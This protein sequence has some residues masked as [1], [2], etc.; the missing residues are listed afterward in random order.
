[1]S[2]FFLS[3]SLS[4]HSFLSPPPSIPFLLPTPTQ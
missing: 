4:F 1:M 2:F 3:V